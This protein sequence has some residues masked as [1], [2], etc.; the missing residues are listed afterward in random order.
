VTRI[1]KK[2]LFTRIYT[3]DVRDTHRPPQGRGLLLT[4][5]IVEVHA[6]RDAVVVTIEVH[7][8]RDAVVVGIEVH[9]V[10]NPVVEISAA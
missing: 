5:S 9:A 10:R 7:A 6:V 3:E 4:A 8:V 2:F 1:T